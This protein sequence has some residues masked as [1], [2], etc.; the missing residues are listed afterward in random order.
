MA[1][2]QVKE[3]FGCIVK[4]V[5]RVFAAG[6]LVPSTD[7]VVKGREALFVSADNVA[8]DRAAVRTETA[9][10]PP[11]QKRTRTTPSKG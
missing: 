2:L 8:A 10:A 7:P 3:P 6:D 1:V 9:D 5:M 4:G 11:A